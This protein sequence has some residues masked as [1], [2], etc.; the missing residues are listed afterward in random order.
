MPEYLSPGVYVEEV[1]FR[2]KSIEGV[3]TSTTGFAGMTRTGPVFYNH[4]SALGPSQCEPRLITSWTEFERVFGGLDSIQVGSSE[5]SAEDHLAY[6]GH[7]VRAFFD[8]GGQRVYIARVFVPRADTAWDGVAG[9]LTSVGTSTA[10]WRARWPGKAGNVL[11]TTKP[12]RSG[13][14]VYV[15]S[16]TST[17]RMRQV[18]SG[19][20]VELNGTAL[21]VVAVDT[22]GVQT[23]IGDAGPAIS[24]SASD[25]AILVEVDVAVFGENDRAE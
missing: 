15:D 20:V 21:Y 1:S 18:K 12:R 11:I 25:V 4:G 13:N 10:S 22:E 9:L 19:S 24:V 7:A 8:N 2:S 17:A 5:A 16:T 6:V 14:L 3:P 23:L